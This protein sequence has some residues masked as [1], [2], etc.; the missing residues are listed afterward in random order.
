MWWPFEKALEKRTSQERLKIPTRFMVELLK[1]ILDGN[2]LNSM[3]IYGSR[4][5]VRR[6]EQRLHQRIL[7]SLWVGW[8]KKFFKVGLNKTLVPNHTFGKG[9]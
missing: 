9:T 3:A 2:V 6:W 4:K 1:M 5:L 7:A 8:K